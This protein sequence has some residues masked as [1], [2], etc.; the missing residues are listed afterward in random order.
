[1]SSI[2]LADLPLLRRPA[3]R[4]RLARTTFAVLVGLLAALAFWAALGRPTQIPA[5][6]PR[7][8]NGVV[9]LDVSA[10]IS[11]DTYAR[12]AATLDRLAGSG[13]RYGLVL[14]SDT[15]YQAL[16]PGTPARE[17]ASFERY[18][19][20]PS[21]RGPGIAPPL[22]PSPWSSEF[23]AGTRISTGL[24]LALDV[25]RGDRLHNPAILLVSDL[26][27]DSGDLEALT[28]IALTLRRLHI[29][30]HVVGL[31]PAPED[32]RLVG[33]LLPATGDLVQA[34]LPDEPDPA[35]RAAAPTGLVVAVA[36]LAAALA[37]FLIL[38]E[39]L[40]WTVAR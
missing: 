36:L 11:S 31:N 34:R 32:E 19:D 12:V 38:T 15:S 20:V 2:P 30:V 1:M 26:D 7:G 16:P 18:F 9:V 22:P 25:I 28:R 8:S 17:L 37:A 35:A 33:S 6:L 21:Q 3:A 27:D 29:A 5:Y 4:T 10:S 23:S 24:E 14:F 40:R 13:G 39:R